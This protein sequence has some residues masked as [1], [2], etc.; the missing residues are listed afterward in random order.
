MANLS[1]KRRHGKQAKKQQTLDALLGKTSSPLPS[2]QNVP[3]PSSSAASRPAAAGNVRFMPR[4]VARGA[5]PTAASDSD[6]DGDGAAAAADDDAKPDPP[7]VDPASPPR[8]AAKRKA[9]VLSDDE[10]EDE[11]EDD[12]PVATPAR[13]RK[14]KV[15]VLDSDSDSDVRP[16]TAKRRRLA[17]RQSTPSSPG[18]PGSSTKGRLRSTPASRSLKSQR[19]RR[20]ELLRRRRN[21][22]KVTELDQI[23]EASGDEEP[24]RALYDTDSDLPALD[25][26]DDEDTDSK[27]TSV[28]PRQ[29]QSSPTRRKDKPAVQEG[30][31]ADSLDSFIDDEDGLIGAPDSVEIPLE[32]TSQA[33]K[34][35]KAL[36]RDIIDW[37]VQNRI[38]PDFDRENAVYRLAWRKLDDE[39]RG[40]ASSKFS[41]A[42]WNPEFHKS[43]RARPYMDNYESPRDTSDLFTTC[44]ACNRTGHPATRVIRFSGKPYSQ[45]T[46]DEIEQSEP[47]SEDEGPHRD[48]DE[49]NNLIAEEGKDWLCGAVCASNAETAHDLLHW[50]HSLKDWVDERLR[51]QGLMSAKKVEKRER[52]SSKKRRKRADKIVDEWEEKGVVRAL[53]DDFKRTLETARVKSTTGKTKRRR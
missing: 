19:E 11:D 16:S 32:F 49:N 36:F 26:F 35:M 4:G 5:P 2:R 30:S 37:L 17:R 42:A 14:P 3:T 6:D 51:T 23:D 47:D 39:F 21:G 20:M 40:L 50:K 12:V 29:T 43:L 46:L 33:H 8:S 9:V 28:E 18:S 7:P 34:P 41:S 24:Q 48:R 25:E 15:V 22:E 31:D 10:G 52:L 53:Y 38:N 45:Q 44:Q 1:G 27:E 13:A